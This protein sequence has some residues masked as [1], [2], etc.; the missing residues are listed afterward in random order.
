VLEFVANEIKEFWAQP[1]IAKAGLM[2]DYEN[3]PVELFP[4]KGPDERWVSV[5]EDLIVSSLVVQQT[6]GFTEVEVAIRNILD[7]FFAHLERFDQYIET[8]LV[9]Y[10]DFHPYLRY[11]LGILVV[12]NSG[13]KSERLVSAVHEFLVGF[14]YV[15]V[16]RLFDRY[17]KHAS[18]I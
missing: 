11:W 14:E 18:R 1:A 13:L 8:G 12:A 4:E 5:N 17:K 3:L 16:L 6:R 9:R 7:Q 10:S 15:G 2:L